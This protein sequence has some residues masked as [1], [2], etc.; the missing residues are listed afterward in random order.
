MTAFDRRLGGRA[1]GLSAM[2]WLLGLLVTVATDEGGAFA[3]RLG[4]M[5]ALGPVAGM[6]GVLG[7]VRQ[8]DARGE[9]R[10]LAACGVEPLRAV[11]GAVFGGA[12]VGLLGPLAA[13]FGLGDMTAL[14]PRPPATRRWL[15]DGGG[16]LEARLGLRVG[17][18]GLLAL[19]APSQAAPEALP[20]SATHAAAAVLAV[21][22]VVCPLWVASAGGASPRR[23]VA[24]G[25]LALSS[26]LV[27]FQTVAAGR[28][29][30]MILAVAPIVLFLDAAL[31]R[32]RAGRP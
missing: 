27:G 21:S 30:A 10:A 19:E 22:A 9:L 26:A 20:S 7:A 17:P 24:V 8:A 23:R 13:A 16:L 3:T 2:A 14:F 18:H 31:T 32:Y 12:L 15:P 5:A 1:A 25:A 11:M 6:L 4:M 28:A 29:P